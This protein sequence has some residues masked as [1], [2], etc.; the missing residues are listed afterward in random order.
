M[1]QAKD[2]LERAVDILVFLPIGAGLWFRDAA[3]DVVDTAV[4]RGRAEYERRTEELQRQITHLRSLGEVAL[5]FGWPKVRARLEERVT[6]LLGRRPAASPAAPARPMPIPK[7]DAPPPI[8]TMAPPDASGS[9]DL[10]IPGYDALSA[11]QVVE[12]L[13]GLGPEELDAV[14]EY[15]ATHRQRRT[16]LGKI[17][18]LAV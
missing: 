7:A 18:Q 13:A 10:P 12:R 14:H 16:I 2:P 5:A 17:E 1:T 11:S 6:D 8:A 9:D 4:G 3:P 15:E